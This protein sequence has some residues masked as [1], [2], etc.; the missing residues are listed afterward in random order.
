MKHYRTSRAIGEALLVCIGL[1]TIPF[2]PR[3]GVLAFARFAGGLGYRFSA[4][5]RR[6]SLA[7]LDLA[8]GDSLT[9]REKETIA[10]QSF[11]NFALVVLDLFWFSVFRKQRLQRYVRMDDSYMRYIP[12]NPVIAVTGHLGNWEVMGQA[13]ALHGE[14]CVSVYTPTG[15]PVVDWAIRRLRSGT[16]QEVTQRS[17]ALRAM[18]KALKKGQR[19]A[20][21]L[22]QN[23]LP[24]EGGT[25]VEFFGL[26]VPVSQAVEVMAGHTRATVLIV[27][28]EM[29]GDG[30]Y[31]IKVRPLCNADAAE[32]AGKAD[33][34]EVMRTLEQVIREIPG[35]W[36][37]SYKRWKFIP[38]GA[39]AE[40]YPF[41]ARRWTGA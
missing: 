28:C 31:L 5:L 3:F 9:G 22:D 29:M 15:N 2:L 26:P 35:Q 14:P 17:G 18:L 16:G 37:W 33:T 34:A 41:Y 36:L 11:Q 21:L 10:R 6:I 23:T 1:V 27:H 7:N 20:L 24:E 25:F 40:R 8:F 30:G 39:P 19:V 38:D 13:A 4:K 12:V 32:G